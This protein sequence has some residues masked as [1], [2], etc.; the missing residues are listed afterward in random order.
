VVNDKETANMSDALEN[1]KDKCIRGKRVE[2]AE[3]IKS[4]LADGVD[5][6]DIMMLSL[7]PAMAIV[8]EKYSSGE[9]FLPQMMIA[10][11][12][13]SE[14]ME[15]LKSQLLKSNYERRGK[16][17]LGTVAGDFHD[18]GKNIVKIMLEGGGYEV[19]DLGVD[20]P[21]EKFIDAV[22]KDSVQAV[23]MSSLITLTMESM[24][25]TIQALEGA[26]LRKSVII[27]VGGAPV[28]QKFADEIGADF[29]SPD[30]YGAVEKCNALLN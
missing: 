6:K 3:A 29:Y 22:Q 13:M 5:A 15:V 11:R 2:L 27:G 21:A 30:A 16:V 24:R 28:T 18:I 19:I 7:I 20:T 14:A 4:A 10:A 17:A 8:G 23:L 9:F 25:R 12:A 1:I 26:G